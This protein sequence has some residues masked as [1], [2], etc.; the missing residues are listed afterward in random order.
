MNIAVVSEKRGV[1]RT[2]VAVSL[3][4]TMPGKV[5]LLDCDVEK[6][7]CH[8]FVQP[9]VHVSFPIQVPVP[10]VNARACNGCG[11]CVESCQFNALGKL[12]NGVRFFPELC[13]ACGSC[14]AA[15]TMGAITEQAREIGTL[16]RGTAGI[17]EFAQG[18]LRIG[19]TMSL[20]VIQ[21][22]KKIA[23]PQR[24]NVIDALPGSTAPAI[25]AISDCDYVILVAL[26][27]PSGLHDL[28][29]TIAAVHKLGLPCG[30]VVN[31]VGSDD[32]QVHDYCRHEGISILLELPDDCR[33]AEACS[34]GTPIIKALPEFRASFEQLLKRIPA[35]I[36]VSLE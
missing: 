19:E 34:H 29:L 23:D 20:P 8:T 6:P 15:C 33:I 4:L 13:Q 31:R 14:A 32:R 1:G 22:L 25:A 30:V 24:V 27:T 16:D 21:A 7:N 3:A 35:F 12:P 5:R 11:D 28:K 26:P 9:I 10:V 36:P 2:T 18:R 17:L